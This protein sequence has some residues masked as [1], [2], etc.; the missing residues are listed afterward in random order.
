[1]RAHRI[2]LTRPEDASLEEFDLDTTNLAPGEVIVQSLVTLISSGTDGA[3][4]LNLKDPVNYQKPDE[5]SE[6]LRTYPTGVGS[7]IV[8]TVVKAGPRANMTP[9]DVVFTMAMHASAVCVDTAR[10][11]CVRVPPGLPPEEAVFVR[12]AAVSTS[13]LRTTAARCGDRAAVVG[14]GLVG[15]LAAQQCELAGMSPTTIEVSPFRCEVARCCGLTTVLRAPVQGGLPD[16]HRLVIEASGTYEGVRSALALVRI[17]GD[18]SLVG[19]PWGTATGAPAHPLLSAIFVR[20][21]CVRSGWE[22]QL[23]MLETEAQ[24][25]SGSIEHNVRYLLDLLQEGKLK[26]RPLL[27]HQVSPAEVQ[28]AFE[29]V[30]HDKEHY[31]GVVFDW[32]L[33]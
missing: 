27:T 10:D 15:N 3:H 22:W 8:G 23:P 16:D 24:W 33:L 26:V 6:M 17:G 13:T 20:K 5:G 25:S 7:A 4:F 2:V 28:A 11:V 1:M 19:A 18:V 14:L 9:G 31:L 12:M 30:V 21:V 32:R 29:G